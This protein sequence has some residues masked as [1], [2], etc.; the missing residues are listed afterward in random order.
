M[1]SL[2]NKADVLRLIQVYGIREYKGCF[3]GWFTLVARSLSGAI[4]S[5]L[6]ASEKQDINSMF[7][8]KGINF[9]FA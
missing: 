4:S 9:S 1:D 7:A 8:S 5:E 6:D 2:R 3:E